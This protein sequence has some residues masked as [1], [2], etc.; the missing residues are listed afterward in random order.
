MQIAGN[1]EGLEA[2][3]AKL[4]Q[5]ADDSRNKPAKFALLKAAQL[6]RDAARANA[7]AVNDPKTPEEIAKNVT[8][9]FSTKLYRQSGLIQYRVGILGGARSPS[10]SA[11]YSRRARARRGVPS[12]GDLGE[13]EGKG[14]GNPG[15]DTFYWRFL[16]FGTEK[17]KAQ[18]F[19]RRALERNVGRAIAE[20]TK[21]YD[22]AITRA[23]KRQSKGKK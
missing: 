22:K 9:R 11:E 12:L 7:A 20:F 16:E 23:I 2:I 6:V 17:Q 18:P 15:G 8:V 13:I 5:L 1:I 3:N 21:H 14:K 4:A 19:L 10:R